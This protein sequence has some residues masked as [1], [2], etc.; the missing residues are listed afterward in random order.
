MGV[1]DFLRGTILNNVWLRATKGTLGYGGRISPGHHPTMV[2]YNAYGTDGA[3]VFRMGSYDNITKERGWD[4]HSLK[5]NYSNLFAT[6]PKVPTGSP[7][8]PAP[9]D[10]PIPKDWYFDHCM[11]MPRKDSALLGAGKALPNITGPYLGNAPDIGAHQTGL[12]TAWYGPRTWDDESGLIY[13]EPE[14]WKKLPLARVSDYASLG[15]PRIAGAKALLA[16]ESPRIFALMWK[17]T[18]EGEAR[19]KE[20]DRIVG[21]S[22]GALSGPLAFQ[23]GLTLR[24]YRRAAAVHLVAGRVEPDGVLYA[25]AGCADGDLETARTAMFQ[26]MR[27]LAR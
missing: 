22:L 27:S 12:G 2:D 25:L 3:E 6:L 20:V 26:F 5:V 15:C 14:G 23:D 9:K 1:G 18:A 21:D 13:G 4:R 8:Y 19:W 24:L 11:L 10:Q 17:K 16:A 7:H